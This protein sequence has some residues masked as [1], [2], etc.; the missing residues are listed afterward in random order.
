MT[1]GGMKTDTAPP[2]RNVGSTA[3][4]AFQVKRQHWQK[5]T[6]SAIVSRVPVPL[7]SLD[8]TRLRQ[9]A[10]PFTLSI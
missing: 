1:A 5:L 7:S 6:P 10:W 8:A 4:S 3:M 9:T 2:G